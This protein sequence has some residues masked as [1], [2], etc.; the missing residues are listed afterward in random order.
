MSPHK[1]EFPV[2]IAMDSFTSEEL[3][4]T[5]GAITVD[6]RNT[7]GGGSFYS[8]MNVLRQAVK[9]LQSYGRSRGLNHILDLIDEQYENTNRDVDGRTFMSADLY[10]YTNDDANTLRVRKFLRTV[11][12]AES[13]YLPSEDEEEEA[14][15]SETSSE[16]SKD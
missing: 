2:I 11:L 12:Q 1:I 6:L 10:G 13:P 4:V 8:R 14:S 5:I 16:V 9:L 15:G 3:K 7:W